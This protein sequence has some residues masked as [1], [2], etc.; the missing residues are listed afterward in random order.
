MSIKLTGSLPDLPGKKTAYMA[1]KTRKLEKK[2]NW[3]RN[4]I[5]EMSVAAGCGHV[6][7][8]FSCTELL[9]ALYHGGILRFDPKRPKWEGR[10]RFILSKGQSGIALYPILADLGFFPLSKLR[11][12]AQAGSFLGVHSES[13]VPGIEAVTGSLGHGIGLSVGAALR[14]KLDKKRYLSI[15]MLGDA[16]CYE[17]SVWEAA[18]FASHHQLDNLIAIIDRNGMGVLDFTEKSLKI[19]PL[20]EKWRSFG[21]DAST[22]NGHCFEEIFS[23]LKDIRKRNSGKPYVIIAKTVKGKGVSFM[24]NKL[25]WHYRSPVGKEVELARKELKWKEKP[26]P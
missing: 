10:D 11:R 1:N 22:I 24:E 13:N 23:A 15:C 20:E 21:W 14:A 3:V 17:G 6:S 12:F 18:M 4:Q 7:S 16:E 8:S 26:L 5:L 9:V 2:A 25:F 19:E